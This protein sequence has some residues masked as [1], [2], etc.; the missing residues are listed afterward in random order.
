MRLNQEFY[1][2]D[3]II[4]SKKLLGKILVHNVN[5]HILKGYISETEAYIASCDKACHAYGDKKTNR[6]EPLFMHG[7]ISYVYLIYGMYNCFNIV[8][9]KENCAAAVLIRSIIPKDDIEYMSY[10]RYKKSYNE[11]TKAQIKNFSNGPGKLCLCMD[12]TRAQ[13]KINLINDDDFY[14]EDNKDIP[15]CDIHVSKRIGIDYAEEAKDFLWRFFI[16]SID[17]NNK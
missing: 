8:A 5:G 1:E 9:D 2:N 15:E 7:G 11:L 16:D 6:T 3:A 13:N 12:I 10:L 14:I 17:N 4:L